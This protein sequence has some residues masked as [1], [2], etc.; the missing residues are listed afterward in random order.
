[1]AEKKKSTPLASGAAAPEQ[2]K[3]KRKPGAGRKPAPLDQTGEM[4][5]RVCGKKKSLDEFYEAN[6]RSKHKRMT[7]CIECETERRFRAYYLKKLE[8]KGIEF[9]LEEVRH[10][11]LKTKLIDEIVAEYRRTHPG[12]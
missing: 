1:M 9:F 7:I 11:A 6:D 10:R 3:K 2:L 12:Q 4:Q 8:T 5:C